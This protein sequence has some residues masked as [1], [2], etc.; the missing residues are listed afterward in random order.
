MKK[1]KVY[2]VGGGP[3]DP[4]L[5]TVKAQRL[6]ARCE[7]LVYDRLI[8]S[9]LLEHC[10]NAEMIFVGKE[11]GRH[12]A[13]Q[14]VINR[15]LLDKAQEGKMVVRLKG[16]DP[17]LFGR[18]S[19]ERDYLNSFGIDCE[20]VPGVTS[21]I[22]APAY[23]GIP[24]TARGVS[25]S[26]HI[27][28]GHTRGNKEL[29]ANY[30]ALAKAGGT[31]VFLMAVGT[32]K[33]ITQGLAQEGLARETPA[34]FIENGTLESQRVVHGTLDTIAEIARDEKINS[35]AILVIGEVCNLHL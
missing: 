7:V 10:N 17:F 12:P 32:C 4:E 15:I 6:L 8:N 22:A 5:L 21:A 9:A 34:A 14:E 26:V 27:V 23:A 29:E 16:G 2:L 33:I 24:V 28:T 19:E 20:V 1:G 11:Q 35:P 18:G 3:G 31:L 25:G 30:A 13:P